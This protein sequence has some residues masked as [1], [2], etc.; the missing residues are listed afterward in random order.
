MEILQKI[1]VFHG[2]SQLFPPQ[3]RPK[4][5]SSIPKIDRGAMTA[6]KTGALE[7]WAFS[8]STWRFV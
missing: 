6:V 1:M 5:L 2:F 7:S 8:I 4:V 3:N